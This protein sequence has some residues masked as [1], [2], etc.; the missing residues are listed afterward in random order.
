ML[1]L[2][3]DHADSERN[4][5]DINVTTGHATQGNAEGSSCSA[6]ARRLPR[7]TAIVPI[8]TAV[9]ITDGTATT[10]VRALSRAGCGMRTRAREGLRCGSG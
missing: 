10:L 8:A 4:A 9:G 5:S 7:R 2:E 6:V 1:A 3:H